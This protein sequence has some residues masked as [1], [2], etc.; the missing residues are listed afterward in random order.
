MQL[1][2][3]ICL[4]SA[5]LKAA[6]EMGDIVHVIYGGSALEKSCTSREGQR[7]MLSEANGSGAV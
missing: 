5:S 6:P 3:Q 4:G 2:D 7:T 1:E